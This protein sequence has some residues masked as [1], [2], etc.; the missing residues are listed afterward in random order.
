MANYQQ[1]SKAIESTSAIEK[2]LYLP[3]N[4]KRFQG[5]LG[6]KAMGYIESV[7]NL[8]LSSPMLQKCTPS[9]IVDCAMDC[10]SLG[11]SINK[12]LGEAAIIPFSNKGT[13]VAQLQVMTDGWKH[14]A[15]RSELVDEIVTRA[16]Y[17]TDSIEFDPESGGYIIRFAQ[18]NSGRI[19]PDNI[20]KRDLSLR[21]CIAAGIVGYQC[22]IRFKSGAK[23]REYWPIE[24][25]A[26]H[27]MQYSKSFGGLWTTN[28]DAMAMKTVTKLTIKH[29]VPVDNMA[30]AIELDQSVYDGNGGRSYADNPA[31]E[32]EQD[33]IDVTPRK[34]KSVDEVLNTISQEPEKQPSDASAE[35]KPKTTPHQSEIAS[36]G[37][38]RGSG[39]ERT[40]DPGS[41]ITAFARFGIN[42][43]RL[44]DYIECPLEE[45]TSGMIMALETAYKHLMN[46]ETPES[47]FG[48]EFEGA[49]QNDGELPW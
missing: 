10:A 47:V 48:P 19:D 49:P 40:A 6:K 41:I 36:Q 8:F 13:Y 34:N 42:R 26:S 33:V 24:K 25:I 23:A 31:Y 38:S 20:Q 7:K 1:N 27:G 16:V 11:L 17:R 5:A 14:L 29:N 35:E 9:S 46:G 30:L 37:T 4:L 28:F 12:N 15:Y 32:Q 45:A 39:E 44:E 18:I 21:G 43:K 3:K 2:E 22:F